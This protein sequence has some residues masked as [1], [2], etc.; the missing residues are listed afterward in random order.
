VGHRKLHKNFGRLLTAYHRSGLAK[1]F[2]LRVVSPGGFEPEES[3][4]IHDLHLEGSVG[5]YP[6]V[7]D[8]ALREQYS[9]ATALVYPSEYEGFGLPI[10]EA[11]A[12]GV[13]VATSNA[14]SMPEVGGGAAIYFDP[15]DPE[16]IAEGLRQVACL[17]AEQRAERIEQGIAR[18]RTFTWARCQRQ[19]LQALRRLADI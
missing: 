11:M 2:D 5:F 16:S 17:P 10:L 3:R 6:A 8:T 18:A 14:A 1:D 12:S 15:C 9:Q 7:G 19:T 4:Q 13:L